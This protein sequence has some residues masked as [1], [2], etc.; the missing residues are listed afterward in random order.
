MLYHRAQ[1]LYLKKESLLHLNLISNSRPDQVK[2]V[3]RVLVDLSE[4]ANSHLYSTVTTTKL[5]YCSVDADISFSMK[6]SRSI[7]SNIE[8]N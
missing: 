2:L 8:L 6:L 1:K 4:V 3:G 5:M 7:E